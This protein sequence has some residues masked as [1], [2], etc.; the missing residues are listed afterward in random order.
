MTISLV[1]SDETIYI[2]CSVMYSAVKGVPCG[3]ATGVAQL[4]AGR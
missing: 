2:R 3:T 1:S 4:I